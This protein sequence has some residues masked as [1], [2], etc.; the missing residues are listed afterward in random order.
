M[1]VTRDVDVEDMEVIR[2]AQVVSEIDEAGR[3]RL[4]DSIVDHDDVLVE[5]I[6]IF[7][8]SRVE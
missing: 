3:G 1:I 2:L 6:F 7:G 8:C 4:R 5:V